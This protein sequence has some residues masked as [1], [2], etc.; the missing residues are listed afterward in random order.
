MCR[1]A[2]ACIYSLQLGLGGI[3]QA[4]EKFQANFTLL[5]LHF[6]MRVIKKLIDEIK[7]SQM[8]K[9]TRSLKTR[10]S[11][12]DETSIGVQQFLSI[13]VSLVGG[14]LGTVQ[15]EQTCAHDTTQDKD[16][17]LPSTHITTQHYAPILQ[18]CNTTEM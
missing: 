11:N 12:K 17:H 13:S 5:L 1:S 15:S 18:Y 6:D 9:K 8:A 2:T 4:I 10:S 14:H 16:S 7:Q 3:N